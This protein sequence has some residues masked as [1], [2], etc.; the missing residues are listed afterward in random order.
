MIMN[1]NEAVQTHLDITAQI[2][3]LTAQRSALGEAITLHADE[4]GETFIVGTDDDHGLKVVDTVRWT[5]DQTAVKAELGDDW[6]IAHSKQG[7]VRSL[8]LSRDPS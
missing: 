1:V 3:E 5:L 7:L 4:T 2:K 6:V 8:R